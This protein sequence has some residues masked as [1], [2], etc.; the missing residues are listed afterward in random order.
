MSPWAYFRNFTLRRLKYLI[1]TQIDL[2]IFN[3]AHRIWR[4]INTLKKEK[5]L[6]ETNTK[7]CN[8]RFEKIKI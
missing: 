3:L 8:M 6:L 1:L 7:L 5:T 2:H 4:K